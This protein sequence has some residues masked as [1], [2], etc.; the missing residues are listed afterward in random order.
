MRLAG[1]AA[2]L[3]LPLF[4][5][6]CGSATSRPQ[7]PRSRWRA[8]ERCSRSPSRTREYFSP[9]PEQTLQLARALGREAEGQAIVD[10][11]AAQYAAVAEAHP[12]WA[13]LTATFSQGGPYDGLLYVYPSGLGTDFLTDLGFTITTGFEEHAPKGSQA[14]ISAENV[15]LIDADVIVFATESAE[16]LDE[17]QAFGTVSSLSAVAENRAVYTDDVLAGAIY[18]DTPHQYTLERL[19]PMLERATAGEAPRQYPS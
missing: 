15:S 7:P 9:W 13:D 1:V 6:S 14:E 3:A 11:V 12:A 16:Q 8:P 5:T 2:V 10:E 18:F 17:L 4:L 19:V